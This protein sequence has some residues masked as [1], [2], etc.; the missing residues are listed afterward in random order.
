M[1]PCVPWVEDLA[2]THRQPTH[3]RSR[4]YRVLARTSP[5]AAA[6]R[7]GVAPASTRS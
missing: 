7:L 6:L 5:G 1:Q 4:R 3:D 2:A